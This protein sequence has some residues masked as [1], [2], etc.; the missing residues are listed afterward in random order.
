MQ[1]VNPEPRQWLAGEWLDGA[2]LAPLAELN[3]QCLDIIGDMA[4]AGQGSLLQQALGRQIAGLPREAR[5]GL[6][7]APYL[8]ADAGFDNPNRWQGLARWRVEDLPREPASNLFV[9]AQAPAFIRG[10]FVYGWHLAR[11]HRQLARVVLG[12]SP[13]CAR[14]IGDL[15][16]ADL[17]WACQHRPGWVSLRW[18]TRPQLWNQLL[19]AARVNDRAAIQRASL[20]GIQ[21][22]GAT[23][24]ERR[25]N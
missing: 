12:M 19:A 22:L 15:G 17:D 6:A 3:S 18:E 5:A 8:L 16:L 11:A 13:N 21:L 14:S 7:S 1:T 9:G 10:V 4:M 23:A 2:A 25:G 20:R 24:L